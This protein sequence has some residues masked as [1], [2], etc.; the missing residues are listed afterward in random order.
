MRICL[1]RHAQTEWNELGLIQGQTD[2]PLSHDGRL[3]AAG[4]RLPMGFSSATC[5]TSPLLRARETAALLGF[6]RAIADARLMEMN[7]G[8]FE[9]CSLAE[10]RHR[11]GAQMA[12]LEAMGL[13][14]RPPC[15]ESPREVAQR[16]AGFMRDCAAQGGDTLLVTHK[17]VLR[18][19]LSLSLGWDM[20][21]KPPVRYAPER[22]LVFELGQ[23]GGLTLL[24]TPPL[25]EGMA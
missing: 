22:A 24:E 9:G 8:C 15:G 21:G 18:A 7:W 3:Q 1:I 16:L 12:A 11:G 17:G 2:V 5:F 10:L 13:D 19:S 4:W 25:R 20:R 14:F 23:A 6:D